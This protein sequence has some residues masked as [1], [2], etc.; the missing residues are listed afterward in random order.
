MGLLGDMP[1]RR[2]CTG[3]F[4][5]GAGDLKPS[6]SNATGAMVVMVESIR[7]PI[8]GLLWGKIGSASSC[9]SVRLNPV[10]ARRRGALGAQIPPSSPVCSCLPLLATVEWQI[11][12]DLAPRGIPI[13]EGV[14]NVDTFETFLSS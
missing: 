2:F 9:A 10:R 12:L 14:Q 7:K 6:S 8:G 4:D 5:A 3:V 1:S 13:S 11:C